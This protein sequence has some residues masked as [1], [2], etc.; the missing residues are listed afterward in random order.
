MNNLDSLSGEKEYPSSARHTQ[1]MDNT[2][3]PSEQD[4]PHET[5]RTSQ[6]DNGKR[7]ETR[8]RIRM[9][10]MVKKSPNL[11]R[12]TG[13]RLRAHTGKSTKPL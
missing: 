7:R 10:A 1:K 8:Q 9:A 3:V 2:Q 6:G 12:T 4:V 11:A 13:R 5:T